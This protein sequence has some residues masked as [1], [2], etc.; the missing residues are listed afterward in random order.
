LSLTNVLHSKS[1]VHKNG[2]SRRS[3]SRMPICDEVRPFFGFYGGKW[4][5]AIKHYPS[6]REKTIVEPFAGSAGYSLRY[7]DRNVILCEID[8][9]L[10]A[11]WAYL[12]SVRPAEVLSIPDLRH[13]QTVDDLRVAQEAKWLI[14][15]WLNRGVSTPR[16]SPS[17]WM[18]DGIRPGS[19]WG[20]RVRQTIAQQV[21]KIRHWRILNRSYKDAPAINS[22]TWFI[23]PPYQRAGR[24]YRF[25]SDEIDYNELGDWCKDR[26]KQVI[27]CE[28]YGANWL[29]FRPLADVKTTR[30]GRRSKEMIW[31]HEHVSLERR[32][33]DRK[34]GARS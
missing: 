32:R 2:T 28:N 29:P 23:D 15:F 24:H 7:H 13:D 27:V 25:S 34:S 31:L 19:F 11:I 18:R 12:I 22:A 20:A 14:G 17:R 30:A 5:D 33:P 21:T 4:R 26:R 10:A 1:A 9:V 16:R 3:Q 6:P 8:P